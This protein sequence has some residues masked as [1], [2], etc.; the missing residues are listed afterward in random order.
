MGNKNRIFEMLENRD[1]MDGAGLCCNPPI[2]EYNVPVVAE[3]APS[4]DAINPIPIP[5]IGDVPK[6]A[7]A[8]VVYSFDTVVVEA[9]TG[10]PQDIQ[11]LTFGLYDASNKRLTMS[12]SQSKDA[13]GYVVQYSTDN[14]NTYKLAGYT[15]GKTSRQAIGVDPNLTYVYR[16]AP[17]NE[18]G[19]GAW[20][21]DSFNAVEA[22]K[23]KAPGNISFDSY[24]A[25]S[26]TLAYSWGGVDGKTDGY[27][28]CDYSTDGGKTWRTA[29]NVKFNRLSRTA[30]K[31]GK[32]TVFRVYNK[33]PDGSLSNPVEAIWDGELT[34][35]A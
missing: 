26:Q 3:V 30:T 35:K 32:G 2:C 27:W 24:D 28:Q 6:V 31:V 23:P 12:W 22:S 20:Y 5:L 29:A 10:A 18:Y 33:M 7:P 16:V 14:G 34:I 25:E 15:V 21:Y 19:Q 1:L 9:N 17:F 4:I 11:S 8:R 13:I